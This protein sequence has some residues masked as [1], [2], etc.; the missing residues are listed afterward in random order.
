MNLLSY[1]HTEVAIKSLTETYEFSSA[2]I[3][4]ASA[5]KPLKDTMSHYLT[6]LMGSNPTHLPTN[7]K[8][9]KQEKLNGQPIFM[10]NGA[11]R[12]HVI[13]AECCLLI[14][15][16]YMT[17]ETIYGYLKMGLN[18]RRAYSSYSLVWQEYK[19]MG[20]DFNKYM[21]QDTISAIQFGIG[22]VHLLL[23]F[24][25]PKILK[26]VSAFGWKADKH[27]GFALLK[28]C[29]E[30]RHIRSPLASLALLAYYVTLTSSAPQILS[31]E[32]VQPAVE[33][34]LDAQ[35]NYP[36]SS[37]FLYFAGCV[38]RLAKNLPLSTQS[39]TYTHSVSQGGWAEA[40]MGCLS[41]YEIAF[42]SAMSLDWASAAA[43][44]LEVQDKNVHSSAFIKYFYGTCM[45]M[46]GDRTEAILAFAN[47]S[48]A[49]DK[50]KKTQMDQYV[51][52]RV[53]FFEQSGYQDMDLHLPAIEILYLWNS[54]EN[55]TIEALE[56]CLSKID[57]TLERVY[58]REK[59]E[60]ELRTFEL[61]PNSPPPDY[62]EYRAILLIMK[63]S[64]LNSLH[65]HQEAIVHLNWVIDHKEKIKQALWIVPFA[66]WE[67][68]VTCWG[69]EDYKRARHLW[70]TAQA[71]SDYDF[72][73]KLS[74]RLN[75]VISHAIELGVPE[76]P[77]PRAEK[78]RSTQGHKRMSF[79]GKL[80]GTV[81]VS[82][83]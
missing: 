74:I 49:V 57:V 2:Q 62:H 67:S 7:T 78:G 3:E 16:I 52:R 80:T 69:I 37:F 50:K 48:Q 81:A 15:V 41:T 6:N 11:L 45:D 29:L 64:A 61:A 35:K 8:P 40:T 12:A 38:S 60:Y 10:S 47:A 51:F 25:P 72:E 1:H 59:H 63:A 83:E 39:F 54:F 36:N 65:R 26:I 30:G 21:D 77:P 33:C 79:V 44:I 17:Q 27:L 28:L 75:L 18:L 14:S 73:F 22:S 13:K 5:K 68:G 19:R 56:I 24:L 32:L 20:Q 31:R 58:E 42:N 43:K 46:A 53:E 76:T 55:M 23:S 34:L 71:Y 70:E 66:Y 4:A 82:N 9:L